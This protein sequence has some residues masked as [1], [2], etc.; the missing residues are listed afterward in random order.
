MFVYTKIVKNWHFFENVFAWKCGFFDLFLFALRWL[1][2]FCFFRV[3]LLL[4]GLEVSVL[5]VFFLPFGVLKVFALWDFWLLGALNFCSWIVC[6]ISLIKCYKTLPPQIALHTTHGHLEVYW[7]STRMIFRMCK[8][9]HSFTTI[10]IL[11]CDK[12]FF[13]HDYWWVICLKNIF[14]T[15]VQQKVLQISDKMRMHGIRWRWSN[16]IITFLGA[17]HPNP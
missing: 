9:I 10:M 1:W 5:W 11:T 15:W 17:M 3:V 14:H 6:R 13:L 12:A 7:A 8:F 4:G 16:N 2:N